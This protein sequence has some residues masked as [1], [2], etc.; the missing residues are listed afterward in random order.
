MNP[1]NFLFHNKHKMLTVRAYI[2][3]AWYRF[4]I[5][6]V[7]VKHIYKKWGKE[8]EE[9]DYEETEEN[10]RYAAKVAFVVNHVCSKTAWKSKCLVR[11]LTAQRLLKK[12]HISS[13]L[14]LGCATEGGK[15]IAHAWLRC[16]G[17]FVS[18]GNGNG[19]AVVDKFCV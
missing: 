18:G 15:M 17:M 10:Y 8:G 11:A 4:Q 13:T 14:Y 19:Y 12:K 9:S 2:Y 5:L 7:D 16:G 1:V 6:F 3:S